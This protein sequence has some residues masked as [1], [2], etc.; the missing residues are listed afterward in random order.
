MQLLTETRAQWRP[1]LGLWRRRHQRMPPVKLQTKYMYKL[2]TE[3]GRKRNRVET[4]ARLR[5]SVCEWQNKS[6]K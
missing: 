1:Q 6:A 3:C 4:A 5:P 2:Y